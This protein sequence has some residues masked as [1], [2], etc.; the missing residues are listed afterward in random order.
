M[1]HELIVRF[2]AEM[3][4]GQGIEVHLP[5]VEPENTPVYRPSLLERVLD[6]VLG[7]RV[8][9]DRMWDDKLTSPGGE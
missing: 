3:L 6:K 5:P 4:K 9:D 7:Q 2:Q 8:V 1:N